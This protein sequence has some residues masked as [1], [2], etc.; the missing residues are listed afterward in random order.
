MFVLLAVAGAAARVAMQDLPNVAP[1]AGIA[2]F[3]GYALRSRLAATVLPALMMAASD[4][5]IGGYDLRLMAVV[6][7]A[8]TLP[9]WM[10]I[11]LR[12]ECDLYANRGFAVGRSLAVLIASSLGA[13]VL[14]FL[15]TNFAVW[16]L[17]PGFYPR[18]AAGLL[19]CYT[20][21]LPFFRNTV[22]GNLVFSLGLFGSYAI[23]LQ[24]LA[25]KSAAAKGVG[26]GSPE[27]DAPSI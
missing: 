22:T 21:A 6:Y 12:R 16:A 2:L 23:Y 13:S 17:S 20:A 24:S 9:V 26:A 3:A 4:F 7:G 5:F 27:R 14:F 11:G 10:G 18:S 19:Q 1:I 8:L 25:R 15:I